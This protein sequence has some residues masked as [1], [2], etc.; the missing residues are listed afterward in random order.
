MSTYYGRHHHHTTALAAIAGRDLPLTLMPEARVDGHDVAL[1]VCLTGQTPHL[2]VTS[3]HDH[4][5]IEL[6]PAQLER[7]LDEA[8]RIAVRPQV[9]LR[10]VSPSASVRS[11][12]NGCAS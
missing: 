10:A 12:V 4:L 9:E 5:T 3:D 6:T 1:G 7:L 2:T 8:A 11:V